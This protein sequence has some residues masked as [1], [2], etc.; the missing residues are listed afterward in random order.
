MALWF[1]MAS[2]VV[3]GDLS[4]G[5]RKVL[6]EGP[7]G[8]S[9]SKDRGTSSSILLGD[10]WLGTES[11]GTPL[12]DS[13]PLVPLAQT[14]RGPHFS[15][16]DGEVAWLAQEP[17]MEGNEGVET[18]PPWSQWRSVSVSASLKTTKFPLQT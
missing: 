3:T 15:C 18:H 7:A 6:P 16:S 11:G 2:W 4:P 13:A 5:R 14:G 10:G 8:D 9:G 12:L 1:G 17:Q